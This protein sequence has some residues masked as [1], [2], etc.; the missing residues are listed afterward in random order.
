[1]DLG[2][3]KSGASAILVGL[4]IGSTI[5]FV[6]AAR[7]VRPALLTA[8]LAVVLAV[9]LPAATTY[10]FAKLFSRDGHAVRPL[11]RADAGPLE[12]LDRPSGTDA[13]VPAVPYAVSTPQLVTQ[14]FWRDLEFWNKSVRY[15]VHYPPG[16]Y[17][18]AVIWFPNNAITFDPRTGRANRSLTPF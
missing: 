8:V 12:R 18:D 11:P 5:A 15:G 10:A 2:G 4:T 3:G 6:V 14:K 1:S 17:A 7:F 16:L 13:K 9:A